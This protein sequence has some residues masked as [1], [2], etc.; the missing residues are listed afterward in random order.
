MYYIPTTYRPDQLVHN[1]LF[2]SSQDH[3]LELFFAM[4]YASV[5]V[6]AVLCM[7]FVPMIRSKCLKDECVLNVGVQ[8]RKSP[9]R[10]L[11]ELG[12]IPILVAVRTTFPEQTM[13]PTFFFHVGEAMLSFQEVCITHIKRGVLK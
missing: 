8:P 1:S 3:L 12:V 2:F 13:S 4:F 7:Y 11:N 10:G 9:P 5:N 6:G